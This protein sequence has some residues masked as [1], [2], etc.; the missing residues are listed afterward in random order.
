MMIVT[1]PYIPHNPPVIPPTAAGCRYQIKISSNTF[2]CFSEEEYSQQ[3]VKQ[4]QEDIKYRQ[5]F[6]KN[7]I[8]PLSDFVSVWWWI[9][10]VVGALYIAYGI[11]HKKKCRF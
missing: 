5:D 7:I 6:D 9:P 1:V 8:I 11:Y 2:K 10:I 3:Q 4:Q